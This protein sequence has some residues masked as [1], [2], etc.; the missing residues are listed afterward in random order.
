[1]FATILAIPNYRLRATDNTV[2]TFAERAAGEPQAIRAWLVQRYGTW[3]SYKPTSEPAAWP[4]WLAPLALLV[5][6][7][8][9][10]TQVAGTVLPYRA[11]QA[12]PPY[13]EGGPPPE[14]YRGAPPPEPAEFKKR[15]NQ[16]PTE[17]APVVRIK[18]GRSV[19]PGL[20]A[21]IDQP[22]QLP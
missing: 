18:N 7:A 6:G 11:L 17:F 3:I 20:L 12:Q 14:P 5:V 15:Y 2:M 13:Q 19:T 1:M 21:N 22:P 8:W 16:A 4:L 9:L 10:I